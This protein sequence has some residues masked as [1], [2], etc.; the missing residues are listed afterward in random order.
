MTLTQNDQ[1]FA[2][3]EESIAINEDGSIT[4]Q[5]EDG[6]KWFLSGGEDGDRAYTLHVDP[7]DLEIN[8]N[9]TPE[10][11]K[12]LESADP[13]EFPVIVNE[14]SQPAQIG[15]PIGAMLTVR[16]SILVYVVTNPAGQEVVVGQAPNGRIEKADAILYRLSATPE[17]AEAGLNKLPWDFVARGGANQIAKLNGEPFPEGVITGQDVALFKG[18]G[19]SSFLSYLLWSHEADKIFEENP[20]KLPVRLRG[21]FVA[22]YTDPATGVS[23]DVLG[24]VY[25][26]KNP[27]GTLRYLTYIYW[28]SSFVMVDD[29][30]SYFP[31]GFYTY[32]EG[33]NP[34][35]TD[36][37][38]DQYTDPLLQQWA[39]K[40]SVPEELENV[41]VV[42]QT[43][44]PDV[45]GK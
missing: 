16:D 18:E 17:E 39:D 15:I 21:Y 36:I 10:E 23:K 13:A 5:T 33:V 19:E 12:I 2:V 7:I 44:K 20:D 40:D 30:A 28:P 43:R 14:D 41:V 3:D 42:G 25:Q 37:A 27:D 11:I 26:W 4:F 22:E 34:P 1:T 38:R 31:T 9:L 45:V 29:A 6:Q 24:K 8:Q 35:F 32:G